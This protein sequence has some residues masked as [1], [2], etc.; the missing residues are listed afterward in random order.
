MK[1]IFFNLGGDSLSALDMLS[2]VEREFRGVKI[3]YEQMFRYNT[4][5]KLSEFIL[6]QLQQKA[7][8][9]AV[10]SAENEIEDNARRA[11]KL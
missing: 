10:P 5:A 9:K 7:L 3:S 6:E 11:E 4:I 1:M 8:T 2:D